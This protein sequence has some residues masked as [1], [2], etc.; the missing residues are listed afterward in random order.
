MNRQ[1]WETERNW[2][3]IERL[4][5]VTCL[6]VLATPKTPGNELRRRHNVEVEK[7][8]LD[9]NNNRSTLISSQR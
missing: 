2:P 7:L 6:H 5:D 3:L 4:C 1:L 9:Y 8:L